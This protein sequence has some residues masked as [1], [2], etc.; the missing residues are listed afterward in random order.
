MQLGDKLLQ[1]RKE[2]ALSQ[3]DLAER[4]GVTRQTVPNWETGNTAPD[5]Q[6]AKKL[7]EVFSISL[8]DLLD[9]D[10]K[11][12][13]MEKVSNTEKLAGLIIKILKVFALLI[14]AWVLMIIIAIIFFSV[15]GGAGVGNAQVSMVLPVLFQ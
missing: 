13:I 1:L 6:Q 4:L 2:H 8:D 3:E 7:S 12:I 10:V 14:G 9:N 15:R 11:E 5:I